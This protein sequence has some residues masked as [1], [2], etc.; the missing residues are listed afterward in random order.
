M[1]KNL[2]CLFLLSRGRVLSAVFA[3]Q[4]FY[5]R[6]YAH[7]FVPKDAFE[8]KPGIYIGQVYYNGHGLIPATVY[9]YRNA[10][11]MV[12]D[13]RQNM[14]ENIK[15]LCNSDTS[16][17]Y[18]QGQMAYAIRG[19]FQDDQN[20]FIG[21]VKHEGSWKIGKVKD[22]DAYENKGLYVWDKAGNHVKF[23]N[24]HLL[25]YNFSNTPSSDPYAYDIRN[26]A[27]H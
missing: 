19:G 5:W 11:V 13:T 25:K 16:K 3:I 21:L 17:F 14:K 9:P 15:I 24:F 12:Y 27:I 22:I 18:W 4:D 1:Y 6:D 10:A 7:G 26:L 23:T 20:L 2:L 8:G